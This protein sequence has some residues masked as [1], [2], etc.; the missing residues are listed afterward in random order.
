MRERLLA[1]HARAPSRSAPRPTSETGSSNLSELTGPA[2]ATALVLGVGAGW[3]FLLDA[4][5]FVA[6]A[7]FLI[8]FR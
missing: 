5:T 7:L 2:I 8:G 3:A 1:F 4:A 6:P